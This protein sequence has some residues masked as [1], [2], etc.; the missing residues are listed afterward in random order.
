MRILGAGRRV[1]GFAILGLQMGALE[2][3]PGFGMIEARWLEGDYVRLTALMFGVAD[4]A[5]VGLVAV[6]ALLGGDAGGDL[7]VTGEAFSGGHL[8]RGH[9]T[10]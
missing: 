5:V 2:V 7:G 3:G 8:A 4:G 1:A 6:I 9:V 10:R